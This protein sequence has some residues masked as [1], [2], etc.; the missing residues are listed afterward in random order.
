[1]GRILRGKDEAVSV[2]LCIPSKRPPEEAEPIL[3]KWRDMGYKIALM[4]D[5]PQEAAAKVHLA[6][7]IMSAPEGYRGYA[8]SVNGLVAGI[9]A[10]AITARGDDAEWFVC[11][12][13]DTLPDPNKRADKIAQECSEHFAQFRLGYGASSPQAM[14]AEQQATF[15]VMQP[16]GDPWEDSHPGEKRLIGRVAGSPWLGSEWCLRANQGK[17]PLWPEF[18]HM[19]ADETLQCVAQQLGVVWQRD[20]LKHFH[21]HWGRP[22]EGERVGRGDRMPE[23]LRKANSREEWLKSKAEFERLK[24]G[25]FAECLPL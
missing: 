3:K 1:M 25:G 16:T 13:D 24:A 14:T 22:R 17:G 5:T 15:G 4:V 11:A 7:T 20:D 2:W 8:R 23:F 9:V 21:N 10:N 12:G 6:D 18:F 19:F